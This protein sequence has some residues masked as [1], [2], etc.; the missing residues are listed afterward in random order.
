MLFVAATVV[1][2]QTY[3]ANLRLTTA[4]SRACAAETTR[5]HSRATTKPRPS[6]FLIV[7]HLSAWWRRPVR[8][9]CV[10]LENDIASPLDRPGEEAPRQPAL[11]D[12]EDEEARK[13]GEQSARGE[14]AEP[15]DSLEPD[16]LRDPERQRRQVGALDHDEGEEEL[17]P[18][19]DEREQRGHHDSRREEGSDDPVQDLEPAGA[20]DGRRLL[21]ITRDSLDVAVEHPQH[22]R[23]RPD[24]V[25][26]HEARVRVG[27]L[28]VLAA[29]GRAG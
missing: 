3:V 29:A 20:V 25:D 7:A 15:D 23:E 8:R 26:E 22:E 4:L 9:R 17:V 16:E 2:C 12:D 10:L 28:E 6:S 18:G 1:G 5:V 24:V 14:R 11:D 27:Q 13:G 21:Q 19:G